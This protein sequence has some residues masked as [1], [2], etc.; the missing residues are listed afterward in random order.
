MKEREEAGRKCV[1]SIFLVAIGTIEIVNLRGRKEEERRD[2]WM[3]ATSC[4]RRPSGT[5]GRKEGRRK[6]RVTVK[7]KFFD[8]DDRWLQAASSTLWNMKCASDRVSWLDC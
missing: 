7:G 3:L 5:D 6:E 2:D 8:R 4:R 1:A